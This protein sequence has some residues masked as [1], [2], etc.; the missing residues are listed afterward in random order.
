M[1]TFSADLRGFKN[2]AIEDLDRVRRASIIE[3][4]SLVIDATPVDQGFLRGA[5]QLQLNSPATGRVERRDPSG[6][7][8]KAQLLSDLGTMKDV[9]WFTNTMP[10]ASRIEYDGWSA[11]APVGMVRSNLPRWPAIVAAKARAFAS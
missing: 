11:Q 5:W 9:V 8:A 2:R 4:F 6:A 3:F 10:Y 7:A 1:A